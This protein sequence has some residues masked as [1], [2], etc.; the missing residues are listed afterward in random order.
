MEVMQRLCRS[1]P[2]WFRR[3]G[4]QM[5]DE[6]ST[7]MNCSALL[8][9]FV[10]PVADFGLRLSDDAT[11]VLRRWSRDAR[12]RDAFRCA[13]DAEVWT[14]GSATAGAVAAATGAVAAASV[15]R[16]GLDGG[17]AAVSVTRSDFDADGAA[18]A[19]PARSVGG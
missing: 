10:H 17:I 12:S 14:A 2:R 19:S 13:L 11:R 5:P 8:T 16:W 3:R 6:N 7:R 18:A 1:D 15:A 9:C 4:S